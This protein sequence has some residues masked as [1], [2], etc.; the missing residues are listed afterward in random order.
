MAFV[1]KPQESKQTINKAGK[2]IAENEP[3]DPLIEWGIGLTSRWRACHAYP[4]NTFQATL[5]R[6]LKKFPANPI[7][8]QRLKRM[9]TIIEKLRRYPKMQ[10]AR[11]QDIGGVRAILNSV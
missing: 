6:K 8:A 2:I 1:K 5:R 3:N 11:M 4:I 10:L 7:V 9:P